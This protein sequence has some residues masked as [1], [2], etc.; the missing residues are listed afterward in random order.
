[1][2][3]VLTA[4]QNRKIQELYRQAKERD[5]GS[6][7]AFL[8]RYAGGSVYEYFAEGANALLSPRRDRFDTREV[9]RERLTVKDRGLEALVSGLMG[10][11]DVSRSYAVAYTNAGDDRMEHGNVD[12]ALVFYRKALDRDALEEKVLV[13]YIHALG[14]KGEAEAAYQE[15]AKSQAYVSSSGLVL[16]EFGNAP[17]LR[18]SAS[19]PRRRSRIP[20]HEARDR[21]LWTRRSA[22]SLGG[23]R[24][25]DSLAAYDS[26][27]AYQ[28]D[29]PR[30]L[31]A[32][33]SPHRTLDDAWKTYESRPPGQA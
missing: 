6:G 21:Y 31:K 2:H 30:A 9:V 7:D 24:P 16:A 5:D 25:T 32:Q 13:A 15:G 29:N 8:S 18:A 19:G 14:V 20:R 10:W 12:E 3:S 28:A 22:T 23:G 17:P 11:S 33:A 27:L 1:V 4:D 26:V